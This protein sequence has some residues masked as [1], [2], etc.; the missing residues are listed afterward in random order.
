MAKKIM[1]V[2]DEPDICDVVKAVLERAGYEVVP[3]V[4]A[5]EGL[6]KLQK[7]K[8]DL[9]LIDFFMPDMSGREL[10]ER[11]RADS[12]LK[13]TRAAFLTAARF[14]DLGMEKLQKLGALDYIQKPF[15]AEDL[16]KRVKKMLKQ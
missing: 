1:I 6:E 11:I 12:K 5:P 9:I 15:D 10:L 13:S 7:E 2:D 8:V 3:A 4:G 16:I 14:G